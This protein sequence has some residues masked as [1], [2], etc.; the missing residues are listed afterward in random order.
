VIKGAR[1]M[2]RSGPVTSI[3]EKQNTNRVLV[4]KPEGKTALGRSRR[5]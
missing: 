1:R 4:E 5:S 2:R 3:G